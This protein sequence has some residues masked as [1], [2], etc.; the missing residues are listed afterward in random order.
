MFKELF[1]ESKVTIKELQKRLKKDGYVM[2]QTADGLDISIDEIDDDGYAFGMDNQ[3]RDQ[4][5]NLN[6]EK[7]S[8]VEGEKPRW[9]GG[10]DDY[11]DA[12]K[13][14]KLLKS[15]DFYAHMIDDY[16][17]QQKVEQQNKSIKKELKKIGVTSISLGKEKRTV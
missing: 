6:K 4:E 10:P 7:V 13:I 5:I 1:T 2:V 12:R 8:L 16:K 9:E 3:D 11:E 14:E 17:K 15:F